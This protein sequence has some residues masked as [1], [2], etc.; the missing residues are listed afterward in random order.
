MKHFIERIIAVILIIATGVG[1]YYWYTY[2]SNK[3]KD[4]QTLVALSMARGLLATYSQQ[5][6]AYPGV[7]DPFVAQFG[8][9]ANT[10]K[11]FATDGVSECDEVRCPSY[12]ISAQFATN[13]FLTRGEHKITPQGI[14]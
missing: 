10:Y 6:A 9:L 5:Y 14:Q 13:A 8:S 12:V 7:K 11:P 3:S 2:E 4:F 1:C